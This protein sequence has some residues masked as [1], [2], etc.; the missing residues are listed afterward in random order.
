MHTC[1]HMHVHKPTFNP[2]HIN[3]ESA[4]GEGFIHFT[5]YSPECFVCET[6]SPAHLK[7]DSLGRNLICTQLLEYLKMQLIR[8][9]VF[10]KT[11]LHAQR[12]PAPLGCGVCGRT[13]TVM[14][15]EMG[16]ALNNT[17]SLLFRNFLSFSGTLFV[18]AA[19]F[20]C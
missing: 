8:C 12:L 3:E 14:P 5:K 4:R 10:W 19:F 18:P 13:C 9:A 15:R 2:I 17:L 20:L 6:R 7:Y 11:P 16:A 1:P